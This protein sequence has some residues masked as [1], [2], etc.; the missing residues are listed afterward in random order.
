MNIDRTIDISE[1]E[2]NLVVEKFSQLKTER[3]KYTRRW[4]DIQDYVA[5]V[6]DINCEFEDNE[7]RNKQKDIYINDPTGFICT[8]QAGDYLAGIL[9]NL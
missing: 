8:N 6:N 1:K 3:Q 2:E 9:W 4:K 5:I 7:N